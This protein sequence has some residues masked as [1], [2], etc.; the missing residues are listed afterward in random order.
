MPAA[1][2]FDI[3]PIRDFV[4]W[5]LRD[6]NI[7]ID[8]FSRNKRWATHTNDIN[9]ECASEHHMHALD[10]LTMLAA[11]GVLADVVIF[12]PPYSPHQT[13]ECYSGFGHSMKYEDDA[14]HGWSKTRKAIRKVC[15]PNAVVMSFGW[16]T[17]GVGKDFSIEE[18]LLV[19]HGIGHND[20]IC[21]AERLKHQEANLF[22]TDNNDSTAPVR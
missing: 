9:P 10:F 2:T 6:S 3:P 14:R 20:T 11:K 12:D 22:A 15:A 16:N 19:C 5:R 13:K 1:D 17:V 7:S 4:K 18:I 8:C 21:L